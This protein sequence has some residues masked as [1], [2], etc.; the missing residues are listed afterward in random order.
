MRTV[1]DACPYKFFIFMRTVEDACPYKFFIFMRTVEDA[2][3]YK[4]V[5]FFTK[6][7]LRAE[8]ERRGIA[9][10]SYASIFAVEHLE[11]TVDEAGGDEFD[12]VTENGNAFLF[13]EGA[14]HRKKFLQCGFP[15]LRFELEE[16]VSG[17]EHGLASPIVVI[18]IVSGGRN[19]LRAEII[20]VQFVEI[21]V[22]SNIAFA[23]FQMG[24]YP[25]FK[26]H[27]KLRFSADER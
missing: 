5:V 8:K 6:N 26:I 20:L 18:G 25:S 11:G 2:C 27:G 1:E 7:F 23:V 9:S 15:I 13:D 3:P 19:E 14:C 24:C 10:P 17:G 21:K 22:I 12:L 16:L 4:S